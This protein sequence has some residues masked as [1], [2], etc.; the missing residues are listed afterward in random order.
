M[1]VMKE[2]NNEWKGKTFIFFHKLDFL[3]LQYIHD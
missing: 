3:R 2:G 1:K